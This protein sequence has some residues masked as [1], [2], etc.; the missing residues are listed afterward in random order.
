[1]GTNDSSNPAQC[2]L[3]LVEILKRLGA[4]RRELHAQVFGKPRWTREQ[5]DGYWHHPLMWACKWLEERVGGISRHELEHAAF[6][7]TTPL[8]LKGMDPLPGPDE[9]FLTALEGNAKRELCELYD[10]MAADKT[11]P[12]L[13]GQGKPVQLTEKQAGALAQLPGRA[14][15]RRRPPEGDPGMPDWLW[16]TGKFRELDRDGTMDRD[17]TTTRLWRQLSE[18]YPTIL[19]EAGIPVA[20]QPPVVVP[21]DPLLKT[22]MLAILREHSS[23]ADDPKKLAELGEL[24]ESLDPNSKS[25]LQ[26]MAELQCDELNRTSAKEIIK[27]AIYSGDEKR[28]FDQL[29][30]LSLVASKQGRNGGYWMTARGAKVAEKLNGAIGGT[31][32]PT[33]CTV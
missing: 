20:S 29:K 1:M 19:V 15:Q 31:V 33:D 22:N 23:L 3:E 8:G 17:S 5:S 11:P 4:H 28:A 14:V 2:P 32:T 21:V 26:A 10:L 25:I 6:R 7:L 13:K 27:T 12:E 30:R 18:E 9:D 16:M 24:G